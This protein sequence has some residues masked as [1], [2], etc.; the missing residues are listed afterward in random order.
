MLGSC[1]D[2]ERC[3]ILFTV[4][5]QAHAVLFEVLPDESG[6][7]SSTLL[8]AGVALSWLHQRTSR[9]HLWSRHWVLQWPTSTQKVD[10]AHDTMEAMSTL[11]EL[12]FCVR[13]ELLKP[14]DS[15]LRNGASTCSLTLEGTVD[16]P[17]PHTTF[18]SQNIE[19]SDLTLH[20]VTSQS[21]LKRAI[22]HFKQSRNTVLL[23]T[24]AIVIWSQ[25]RISSCLSII[26]YQDTP[27]RPECRPIWGLP[28]VLLS[29]TSCWDFLEHVVFKASRIETCKAY[30]SYQYKCS[31]CR[32]RDDAIALI[33]DSFH[34]IQWRKSIDVNFTICV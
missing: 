2:S 18:S 26:N 6:Y 20:C 28:L 8:D 4:A 24:D 14:T 22:F 23:Q 3:T 25:T 17:D 31:Q 11:T 10:Q 1:L 12:S 30:C 32:D 15:I 9:Q 5:C 29:K 19:L 33:K 34:E 13:S 27:I 7:F 16:Q 21:C